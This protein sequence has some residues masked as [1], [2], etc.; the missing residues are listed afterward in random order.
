LQNDG[1]TCSGNW[2]YCNAYPGPEKENNN[3]ARRIKE[4]AINGIGLY[5]QWAWAW[6][7][8][9]RIIYNR[10]SCD[11]NGKPFDPKR[12]VVRWNESTGKW[13]GDVP[14][15]PWPPADKYPFIMKPDGHAWL[16]AANLNDGPLPEHYE[17]LES[18]VDNFMS[19]QQNNPAIKLWHKVNPEGNAIGDSKKFPII[20][21]T[22][23]V[24]EHWQAGAMSRNIPWLAELVPDV[25][26]ELGTDLAKQKN[27]ENGNKVVIETA[28]GSMEAYAL[29]TRRFEPFQL[30]G[31]LVHEV[32]VI[33]H[34]GYN[35]LARG[36][37]AN[38]LT[39]HIGDANTMIPEYKAFL[40]DVYKKNGGVA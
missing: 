28:R 15:G 30:N 26:V 31:K 9:R 13:E 32:G 1:S 11:I 21:T 14:D 5:P 18:P 27:I 8:N 7:V 6:P 12:W 34:F 33:W 20:G 3:M 40:C 24:S 22:Y 19:S 37:S 10:A 16:F 36:D 25:F 4:D 38:L 35:G 39:A 23:R 2:L 29:V 17:P